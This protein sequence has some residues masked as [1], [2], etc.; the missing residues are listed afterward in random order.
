MNRTRA[1]PVHDSRESSDD[2]DEDTSSSGV[3]AEAG[4]AAIVGVALV[5]I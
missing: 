1:P 5:L 3:T 4:L 2:G